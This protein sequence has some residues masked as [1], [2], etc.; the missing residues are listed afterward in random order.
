[1]LP[2]LHLF[3]KIYLD[4]NEP[5]LILGCIGQAHDLAIPFFGNDGFNC[6]RNS[7][8]ILSLTGFYD[9]ISP[10]RKKILSIHRSTAFKL[11]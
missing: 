8:D 5:K 3:G 1:M 4:F 9:A 6:E 11:R 2:I 7:K 10:K